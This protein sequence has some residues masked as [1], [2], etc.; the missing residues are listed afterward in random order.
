MHEGTE[1]EGEKLPTKACDFADVTNETVELTKNEKR[2]RR[3]VIPRN[4]PCR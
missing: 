4:T 3:A 1:R 2:I